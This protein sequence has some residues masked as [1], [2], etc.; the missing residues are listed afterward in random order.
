MFNKFIF[1]VMQPLISICIPTKNRSA[2]LGEMLESIVGQAIFCQ[3]DLIEVV[4]SDNCSDDGT[5]ALCEGFASKYPKKIKYYRNDNDIGGLNFEKVLS[6]GSGLFLKLHNDYLTFKPDTLSLLVNLVQRNL[7]EKPVIFFLNGNRLV[8][9]DL[10]LCRNLD[11]FVGVCSFYTTW[12]GG[13]GIWKEHFEAIED[14]SIEESSMLVQ[15]DVLFKMLSRRSESVVCLTRMFHGLNTPGR[16]G[17]N[18][19]K[20]FGFNYIKFLK[21]YVS[22]GE[23]SSRTFRIEKRRLL[24]KHILPHYFDPRGAYSFEKIG[25]FRYLHDYRFDLYFYV[26]TGFYIIRNIKHLRNILK[27]RGGDSIW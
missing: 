23:I 5:L 22:S 15:T 19:A 7:T 1:D 18:I 2:I 27:K 10:S 26:C 11:E 24:K 4:I 12:I 13:F 17:Y 20:V 8:K 14:F 25:F 3:T 21:K 16:G 6:L 9:G